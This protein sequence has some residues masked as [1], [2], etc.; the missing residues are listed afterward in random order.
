MSVQPISPGTVVARIREIYL[1]RFSGPG[2]PGTRAVGGAVRHLG[3]DPDSGVGEERGVC[4][5]LFLPARCFPVAAQGEVRLFWHPEARA[6]STQ[7]AGPAH[8]RGA[9][10]ASSDAPQSRAKAKN[11]FAVP[12]RWSR[13]RQLPHGGAELGAF[14]LR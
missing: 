12:H 14:S 2:R 9:S 7:Q 4:F 13:T 5:F 6:R 11:T 1:D 3:A 8:S 10:N